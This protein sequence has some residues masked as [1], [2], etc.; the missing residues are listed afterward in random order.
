M[1]VRGF[2]VLLVLTA[3]ALAGRAL[4]RL[5]APPVEPSPAAPRS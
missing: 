3:A 1:T 5:D 4:A 2:V